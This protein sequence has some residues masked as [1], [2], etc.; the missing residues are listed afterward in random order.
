VIYQRV[1]WRKDGKLETYD[2]LDPNPPTGDVE[3]DRAAEDAKIGKSQ[4]RHPLISGGMS[5]L[6]WRGQALEKGIIRMGVQV[7]EHTRSQ[8]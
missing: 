2:G 6:P 1:F 4:G 7:N 8:L 3:F 5:K